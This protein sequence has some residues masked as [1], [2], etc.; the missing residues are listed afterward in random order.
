VIVTHASAPAARLRLATDP[1]QE[2]P[3][4][5]EAVHGGHDHRMPVDH[6]AEVGDPPGGQH[7]VQIGRVGAAV[8]LHPAVTGTRRRRQHAITVGMRERRKPRYP[9]TA[10]PS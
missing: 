6:H 7:G 4:V 9:W 3:L 8:L 10:P 1:L 5:V 2:D